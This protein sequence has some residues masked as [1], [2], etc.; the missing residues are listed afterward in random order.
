MFQLLLFCIALCASAYGAF[1]GS[2]PSLLIATVATLLAA[3]L[4]GHPTHRTM[5]QQALVDSFVQ[6]GWLIFCM[7]AAFF[8]S[9]ATRQSLDN[10]FDFK[11]G[12]LWVTGI[13]F[14]VAAGYVY[15]HYLK[16]R[17][18]LDEQTHNHA[19]KAVVFDRLDWLLIGSITAMALFLRLY[20]LTDFLPTMHGDEG[21]MG[22]LAL[23]ALHGPAS[24]INPMP[25]PLFSTAFLD[26]P[27]LFHYL[28]AGSLWF[29]GESLY[30]LRALSV[31]FGALCV[32]VVYG[33]G[34]LG[35][36]RIAAFT[37]SWLLAVSHFHLHYSRIALNNIE[38]VWFVALFIF[39]MLLAAEKTKEGQRQLNADAENDP[40]Q[41][42]Q[43]YAPLASYVWAGLS[44]GLSQY[45]YYGSRLIPVLAGPLLLWLWF[46]R[47]LTFAQFLIMAIAV[48]VAYAPL[49]GHYSQSLPAFLNRTKGVSVI[50]P[51]GM[52]HTLGPQAVWPDDIPRLVWE[53]VK[54]NIGFFVWDGDRSA[55]YLTDLGAFDPVT[56]ALFWLGLG[57][58]FARIARFQ[59][60][61]ILLWWGLGLLLAGV[62]T[63]DAPNGPRLVVITTTVYIVGGVFL[64]RS[65]NFVRRVWPSGGQWGSVCVASLL[66]L[67]TFQLNFTTYFQTYAQHTPN[68]VAIRMAHEIRDL[69]AAYKVYLFGAPRLYV[70]YSTLRF[71]ALGTERYNVE[72]V[73]QLPTPADLQT[74]G[75]GLL[76]IVLTH[77][78][79]D[80]EQVVARF[81]GGVREERTDQ[82]GNLLYVT[83]RISDTVASAGDN[84]GKTTEPQDPSAILLTSPLQTPTPPRPAP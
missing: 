64:Q 36:G 57:V 53:Q 74:E 68:S 46:K 1:S 17:V 8:A 56:V 3:S 47:R 83:Y 21:E 71:I 20:Q 16:E 43:L 39:F 25:L 13:L 75:R 49:A 40:A 38:T 72:Q 65:F 69:G 81:P 61:A 18:T 27:T 66:A 51:E 50:S 55:F 77:R 10:V 79:A 15:D 42:P 35:W 45:F 62:V 9:L 80:L 7:L 34:R 28:Q 4:F 37:A 82:L 22:M 70:E 6:Y 5:T 67:V 58:L 60:F 19:L 52:V 14:I 2:L 11:S 63:N 31:L 30:G 24:G 73:D 54:R 48:F 76:V 41:V 78:L 84:R 29:F 26:H 32:P 44:M 23:L 59:E 12:Y 33:I